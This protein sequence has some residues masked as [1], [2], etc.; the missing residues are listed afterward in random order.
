MD[1]PRRLTLLALA[2]MLAVMPASVSTAVEQA[3]SDFADGVDEY[4]PIRRDRSGRIRGDLEPMTCSGKFDEAGW[5]FG[6]DN[7]GCKA[8]SSS[9]KRVTLKKG[10]WIK[11]GGGD[12][13]VFDGSIGECLSLVASTV[14][15]SGR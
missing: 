1:Q 13:K 3:S 12:L 5:N 6:P 14:P 4:G 9:S 11:Y 15:G 2:L 8:G 10:E 7:Y